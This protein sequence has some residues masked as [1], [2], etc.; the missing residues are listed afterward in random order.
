MQQLEGKVAFITGGGSGVALGQAKVFAEEARMQVVIADI[1]RDHLDEARAYFASR[2]LSVHAIQLDITDR[3]A[4]A[5]AADEAERV[6][7]PVQLLCNTAGVSQF[8]P[9]E[10][11]SYDDWD[12]QIDV[13]LKGMIN[14]VQTFMPRMIERRSGGHIVNTASMSAFVALPN[15]AIYCTTKYAVR[16]LSESLRLELEKYDIG[17]SVLCPG[18]VNTNIHE[19]VLARP[20]RYAKTGYYGADPE[21]FK[22]LKAVIESGF[23]P[24]ELGRIVLQAV[25]HN[26]FWIL[27]YPE[28]IPTLEKYNENVIGALRKYENDP[29]YVRRK[30]LGRRMPGAS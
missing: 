23:D 7:G 9:V 14:G 27:P 4:F 24:V 18:A 17:V 12:W 13:N 15:T 5:R 26:D 20:E 25:I 1:R 10:K 29:D 16:G 22:R 2:K 21:T 8:G 3:N 19:S 6:L 30:Q 28:F 11:A